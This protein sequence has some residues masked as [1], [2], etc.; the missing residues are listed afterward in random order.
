MA[1]SS[2]QGCSLEGCV[3]ETSQDWLRED[4]AGLVSTFW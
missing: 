3:L 1:S 2:Q 4:N